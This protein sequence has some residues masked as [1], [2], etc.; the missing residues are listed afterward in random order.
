[1]K[2]L[3]TCVVLLGLCS[4]LALSVSASATSGPTR[5]LKHASGSVTALAMDGPR[6]VYSTYSTD[7]NGVYVWNIRSGASW[8]V[9]TTPRS[10]YPLIG[11]VAIAGERVAW[12]RR[13]VEGNSE[14]TNEDLYTASSTGRGVKS[15]AH[16][17]RVHEFGRDELQRWDGDWIGGLAG[18]GKLLVVSPWTTKPT[19][20]GPSFETITSGSLSLISSGKGRLHS[21]VAGVQ[22]VVSRSVDAGRV[23]V[24]RPDGTIGI[25][26]ASGVLL[27]Q[28]TPCSAQEIAMGGG[29]LVVLTQTKSLEVYDAR[30]G[31]LEHSWQV[32]TPKP[33]TRDGHLKAFGRIALF[34][35]GRHLR[36]LDLNTG[37]SVSL[38]TALSG[39]AWDYGAVGS[40]G[41][42]YA[43]DSSK[44]AGTLVYL[45][46]A[47]VLA[48]I[49]R[50]HL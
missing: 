1:M 12:V 27:R 47:R 16:A 50:G 39:G 45:A 15:L 48:A 43:V 13:T 5:K 49:A 24:L 7:R 25:Y 23:A 40:L 35:V 14:E 26:S 37:R 6:V 36:I 41:V 38:P 17:Y 10:Y 2:R 33:Y 19:L 18:S 8:R 44:G 21:L 31:K 4:L 30:T 9:E 29:R 22:S 20:G 42:V 46:R 11:Q 34:S 3:L 32:K 28:V